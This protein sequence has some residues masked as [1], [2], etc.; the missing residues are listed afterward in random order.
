MSQEQADLDPN[1]KQVVAE[2]ARFWHPGAAFS[3]DSDNFTVGLGQKSA[4]A[5]KSF[6]ESYPDP[7]NL[8]GYTEF[9][10]TQNNMGYTVSHLKTHYE[11]QT[12]GQRS[13]KDNTD[14]DLSY[15]PESQL[16]RK[17][18]KDHIVSSK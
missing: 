12:T 16:A 11:D 5:L 17:S 6:S 15:N 10:L 8:K 14:L 4:S 1:L 9:Q 7:S 2:V 13:S 3:A 18:S